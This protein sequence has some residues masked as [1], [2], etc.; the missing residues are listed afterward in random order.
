MRSTKPRERNP[1]QRRNAKVSYETAVEI[2][3]RMEGSPRGEARRI[4]SDYGV[5]AG[6]I[7]NIVS[8]V[9]H[10][11]PREEIVG[12]G[13]CQICAEPY[14]YYLSGPVSICGK[15][16]C[17]HRYNELKVV[18]KFDNGFFCEHCGKPIHWR[19]KDIKHRQYKPRRFCDSV[20]SARWKTGKNNQQ[21]NAAAELFRQRLEN[22]K[23]K[24]VEARKAHAK[25][26]AEK[27]KA[28]QLQAT[29]GTQ[30]G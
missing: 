22:G 4:A 2:R 16:E 9:T 7:Y 18:Y 10:K 30:K 19:D 8:Y 29:N 3:K 12:S 24:A 17:Y 15:K 20:C 28:Y 25:E 21:E 14:E 26:R 13:F 23:K 27:I 1:K 11:A 5:T 6:T